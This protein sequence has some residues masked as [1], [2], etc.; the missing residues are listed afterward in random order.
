M[1]YLCIFYYIYLLLNNFLNF[2]LL[3]YTVIYF[4]ILCREYNFF[5]NL[6]QFNYTFYIFLSNIIYQAPK[7]LSILYLYNFYQSFSI[8]YGFFYFLWVSIHFSK[9][10]KYFYFYI[11]FEFFSILTSNNFLY[12]LFYLLDDFLYFLWFLKLF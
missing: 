2:S 1:L 5:I 9:I 8:V 7:P 4:F 6:F 10:C 12:F 11:I 3:L